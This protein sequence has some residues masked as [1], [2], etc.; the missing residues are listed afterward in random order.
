M[1]NH[2]CNDYSPMK[3]D[4]NLEYRNSRAGLNH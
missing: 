2:I 3:S 1:R 4:A